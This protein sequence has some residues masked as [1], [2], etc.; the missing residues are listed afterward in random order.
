[1]IRDQSWK[2]VNHEKSTTNPYVV[3][4]EFMTRLARWYDYITFNV[5][6]FGLTTLSQTMGLVTP[7]LVQQFVGAAHK[8]TYYGT[9][10]L[11]TLMVALL[12]PALMGL[13]SDRSTIAWGRRRPFILTGT[14]ITAILT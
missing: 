9:F 8:A 14:I 2:S 11:F 10:R 13:L 6:F 7:L 12:A 4:E 1:M 5:Y 3:K